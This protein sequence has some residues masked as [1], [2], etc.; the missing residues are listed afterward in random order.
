MAILTFHEWTSF[1]EA[2]RRSLTRTLAKFDSTPARKPVAILTAWRGE[3]P[4]ASGRPYPEAVRRKL[5]D[6]ANR[7]LAAEVRRRGLS[8]VPVV[9]AGQEEGEGGVLTAN[10]E[11]SFLVQPVG[12][13]PE[14]EFLAHIKHLLHNPTGETGGGPHPHTQWGG[15][16]K[17]PS[18]PGAFIVHNHGD[19]T[20]PED[21]HVGDHLGTTARPRKAEPYYTQLRYGPRASDS[22]LDDLDKPDDLG[23]IKGR[24]GRRFTLGDG[25]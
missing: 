23:T 13:M 20:G 17:L 21:Y 14:K 19:P 18:R 7:R 4:D 15:V 5:N 12:E 1:N 25:S 6:Q 11:E 9:G 2:A 8:I 3:L 24:P 22:M 16:V 10:R